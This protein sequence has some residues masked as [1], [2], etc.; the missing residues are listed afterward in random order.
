[1]RLIK[2]QEGG[3]FIQVLVE[4]CAQLRYSL[5]DRLDLLHFLSRQV[6]SIPLAISDGFVQVPDRYV[7]I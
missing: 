3:V 5:L 1:M 2:I 7:I 6:Q 4:I